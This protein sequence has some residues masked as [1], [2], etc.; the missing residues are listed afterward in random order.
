MN[1]NKDHRLPIK[2]T[3]L[4]VFL[5]LGS[6]AVIAQ[7]DD[8]HAGHGTGQEDNTAGTAQPS[9]ITAGAA[10]EHAGHIAET[11][12]GSSA[13]AAMD[14]NSTSDAAIGGVT[15]QS[16]GGEAPPDARD[17]HVYSGGYTLSSGPYALPGPRQLHLA[18]EHDFS[19]LR[20]NRFEEVSAD[21]D[22]STYDA[23]AWFGTTYR[24]LVVK[25]E[26][27]YAGGSL[28][29][30]NT[31]FLYSRAITSYWDAQLGL[32]ADFGTDPDKQWLALGLQGLAPYWFEI[33]ATAYFSEGGS[34]AL[35]LEAEYDFLLTQRLILQPRAELD[36]HGKRDEAAKVGSGLSA[37]VAGL[38]L[39]YEFSRQ[40]APYIGVEWAGKFGETADFVRAT[41]GSAHDT[42][43]MAGLRVWF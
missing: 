17:P 35:S 15:M 6:A 13:M 21:G 36:F 30:S 11:E 38:R 41:G 28:E 43:V 1:G 14:Q 33:D 4:V 25:A 37:A 22:F 10:Q 40:F 19:N 23:Q 34:T 39:R 16:Q 9:P 42:R 7:V 32:R 5:L 26:G 31:E 29:E 12:T 3:L 24:R 8:P 18:D 2:R 20:V 27:D